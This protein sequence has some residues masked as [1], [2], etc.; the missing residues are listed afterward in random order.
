M[1]APERKRAFRSV[2]ERMKTM[3]FSFKIV[4]FGEIKVDRTYLEE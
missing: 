3:I 4:R 1:N 2:L